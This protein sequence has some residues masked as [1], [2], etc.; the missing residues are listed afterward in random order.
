[1]SVFRWCKKRG[2][3]HVAYT[4]NRSASPSVMPAYIPGPVMYAPTPAAPYMH[5][6]YDPILERGTAVSPMSPGPR[7]TPSPRPLSPNPLLPM[8][9]SPAYTERDEHELTEGRG[10]YDPIEVHGVGGMRGRAELG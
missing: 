7:R 3:S 6:V 4:R 1:M 10:L 2:P 9:P 8:S 5:D